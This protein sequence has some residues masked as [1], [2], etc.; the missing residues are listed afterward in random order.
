[1]HLSLKGGFTVFQNLKIFYYLL[2]D[3]I[4]SWSKVFP[5]LFI[6]FA[7]TILLFLIISFIFNGPFSKIITFNLRPP[8]NGFV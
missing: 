6:K 3:L 5:F 4:L 1:M 2:S 7:A 8:H